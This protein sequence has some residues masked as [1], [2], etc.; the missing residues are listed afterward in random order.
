MVLISPLGLL[1]P[2]LMT[3]VSQLPS[4]HQLA[5]HTSSGEFPNLMTPLELHLQN[6]LLRVVFNVCNHGYSSTEMTSRSCGM[7]GER[8]P[9]ISFLQDHL[10]Q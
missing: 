5:H 1:H 8:Y 4:L 2:T 9:R 7:P 10:G 6:A 3:I